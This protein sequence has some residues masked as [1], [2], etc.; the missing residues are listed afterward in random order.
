MAQHHNDTGAD[1]SP[2]AN[3]EAS[4]KHQDH[5]ICLDMTAGGKRVL[6]QSLD[7][8]LLGLAM[9]TTAKPSLVG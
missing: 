8:L 7:H 4:L 5:P 1:S 9:L 3:E 6:E 2:R